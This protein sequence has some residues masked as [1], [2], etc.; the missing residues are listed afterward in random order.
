MGK[1][2]IEKNVNMNIK[3][4]ECFHKKLMAELELIGVPLASLAKT[5][6]DQWLRERTTATT[7][8]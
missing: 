4:P 7:K 5:L 3:V 2:N 6:F 8:K 1:N